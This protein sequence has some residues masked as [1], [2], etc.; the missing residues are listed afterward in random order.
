MSLHRSGG[1]SVACDLAPPQS[2]RSARRS[3][4]RSPTSDLNHELTLPL[5]PRDPFSLVYLLLIV[6]HKEQW[7][8]STEGKLRPASH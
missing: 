4:L 1:A 8:P 7:S 2:A 5:L 3:P 6:P